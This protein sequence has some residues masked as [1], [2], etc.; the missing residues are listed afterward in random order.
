M[1]YQ[2]PVLD[3]EKWTSQAAAAGARRNPNHSA[4]IRLPPQSK[5]DSL[6]RPNNRPMWRLA[7]PHTLE[8][9]QR[10]SRRRE[11]TLRGEET[12]G[13]A[14][15]LDLGHG[16]HRQRVDGDLHRLLADDSV[17][18]TAAPHL[19]RA[20]LVHTTG[21]GRRKRHRYSRGHGAYL[22]PDHAAVTA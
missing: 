1:L 17:T 13:N 11:H 2:V 9:V 12:R 19:G 5:G 22:R 14:L 6:K 21:R 7:Q 8:N 16:G 10:H 18:R 4:V 20:R 15:R 3:F